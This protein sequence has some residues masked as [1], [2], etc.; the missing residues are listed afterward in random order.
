MPVKKF[1]N[2]EDLN[3]PV[4]RRAG[5]P[6]LFRAIAGVWAFGRASRRRVV[7]SGVRKFRSVEEMKN[8]SKM[9]PAIRS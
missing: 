6:E 9:E 7:S 5:D 4:W 3:R 8:S 2:V 1:R